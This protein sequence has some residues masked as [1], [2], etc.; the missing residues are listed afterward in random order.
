MRNIALILLLIFVGVD[1]VA[2]FRKNRDRGSASADTNLNYANPVEYFIAG[3]EV[4]GLT[5]LDKNSMIS[6]TGLKVGDKIKIPG[7][8]ISGAIRKLWKHGLVGDVAIN[9]E[10]IEGE[11]VWLIIK[12]SERP[13]LTNFYFSGISKGQESSLKEDLTLIRGKIV[14]DAM[15]RNTELAVKKFFVKKGYLNTKVKIIQERDT[16]S[17]DGI[18]LQIDVNTNSKVKINK[19]SIEGNQNVADGTIKGKMKGTHEH[20][21][22]VL[23]RT[24]LKELFTFKP[25]EFFGSSHP[26]S[27]KEV[28]EF[29]GE[30]VKL[31]VFKGSKFI[32]ADYED[33]KKNIVA[34]YN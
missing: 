17:T 2:Q 24:L 25:F 3:I 28:K 13:R 10:K 34:Y 21:R 27:W 31:N 15:L 22:F 5:I 4:T 30:N 18:R 26:V 32:Q 11:N 23:H 7:D 1:S 16:I 9:V 20:P 12:L 14:N 33:D 19:I 6:L 29:M 8:A